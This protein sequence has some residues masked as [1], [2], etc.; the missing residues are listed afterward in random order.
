MIT[1]K[2]MDYKQRINQAGGRLTK[3]RLIILKEL[4]KLHSHPTAEIIYKLIKKKLPQISLGTV[5]RNLNYLTGRGY[6]KVLKTND[7]KSHYDGEDK[8]HLHFICQE[9]GQIFD[10]IR[11]HFLNNLKRQSFGQ[12]KRIECYL[13]GICKKCKIN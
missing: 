3:Q 2:K 6:L 11:S 1:N 10:L 8:D 4:K 5:Y 9:C 7:N 12:V 13:F